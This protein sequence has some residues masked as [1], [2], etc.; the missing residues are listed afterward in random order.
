LETITNAVPRINASS[1]NSPLDLVLNELQINGAPGNAGEVLTSNGSGVAPTWQAPISD[2]GS[3]VH[4]VVEGGSYSTLQ[5]AVTAASPNDTIIVGPTGSVISPASWG[6][7]IIPGSKRL[8]II[9]LGG[10]NNTNV[11]IGA[12]TFSPTSPGDSAQITQNEIFMKDLFINKVGGFTG[13]QGVLFGGNRPARLRLQGCYIYNG[14]STGDGI[15]VNNSG[16]GSSLFLDNCSVLAAA[17]NNAGIMIDHR[18]GYTYLRNY[19]NIAG[20]KYALSASAGTV[21]IYN[22]NIEISGSNEVIRVGASTLVTVGY[23]TIKNT[24]TNGSGVNLTT[25]GA[26]FGMGDAT[27]AIATGTGYCVNGVA[28]SIFLYGTNTYSNSAAAAY[29]VKVKNSITSIPTTTTFTSSP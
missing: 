3:R 4:L 11:N 2:F 25:A 6:D 5:A 27:F 22:S 18:Q 26:V 16:A 7:V 10:A 20:G 9:G 29:N 28:G 8:S 1:G 14:A 12:V 21:E 19:N 23:S 15:V 13:S 24:V 17:S